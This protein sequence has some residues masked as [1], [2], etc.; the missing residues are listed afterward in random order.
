M[1][2][3]K[4]EKNTPRKPEV[5]MMAKELGI[6]P[7]HAFGLCV[8]FWMWCDSHLAA[9]KLSGFDCDMLDAILEKK[10]AA[11]ALKNVGW[12]EFSGDVLRVSNFQKHMSENAKVRA[13]NT[14]RQNQ[15]RE[16]VSRCKRDKSVTKPLPEE[17][18]E[19]ERDKDIK[20]PPH[21]PQVD[22]VEDSLPAP[23]A[24]EPMAPEAELAHAWTTRRAGAG[25]RVPSGETYPELLAFFRE[26]LRVGADSKAILDAIEAP[27]RDRT[28]K[29]WQFSRRELEKPA[30]GTPNRIT[31]VEDAMAEMMNDPIQKRSLET[32]FHGWK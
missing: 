30:H 31:T 8:R 9:G 29:L 14:L 7:D 24:L 26:K 4:V 20:T 13:S 1:E 16:K 11:N 21:P 3:I 22:A 2:W 18:R 6:H 25:W 28:E 12:I 17:E 23:D 19:E 15:R 5:L 10:G 32:A 27:Q